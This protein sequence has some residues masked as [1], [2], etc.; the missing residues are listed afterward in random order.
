[1]PPNEVKSPNF[2]LVGAPKAGT[3]SL[4][5]YMDQH[6]DVYMSPLKE[7]FYFSQEMRP[8]NFVEEVQP[9]I[10][11]MV[12]STRRYLDRGAQ[13][14]RFAG[15]VTEWEDYCRLFARAR[16]EKAIGEATVLY[17]WSKTAAERI[18][19]RIPEAK[20]LIILRN[21]A[22]R[23]FSQ[24]LQNIS[25]DMVRWSF[26]EHLQAAFARSGEEKFSMIYPFLEL[27]LYADQVQRY[28]QHF[29]A[30]QIRIWLYESTMSPGFLK[31]VW[32]FLGVDSEFEADT[33]K[34][35]MEP[36]IR[37]TGVRTGLRRSGIW[38]GIRHALPSTIRLSLRKLA[39]RQR[40][41][42]QMERAERE[43]LIEYYR[44]DVR[45]LEKL[46]DRDLSAWL[47]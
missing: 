40:D 11:K 33:S 1:M 18:A 16:E 39:Y 47:A 2:F 46:I 20:I 6:P 10:R 25:E 21:P 42:I 9:E 24:Y 37:K 34:R 32:E 31:E 29:P 36:K 23:A 14:L 17:L 30:A 28:Q 43:L 44:E 12:R 22:E 7:P 4:Y 19:A 38:R 27:G 5:H 13:D 41:A 3:T 8:E 45:K 35:Y 15:Y 26:R